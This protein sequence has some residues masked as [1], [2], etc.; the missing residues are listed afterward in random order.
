MD[1]S[2][3]QLTLRE[4]FTHAERLARELIEHL[5]Q[6]FLPKLQTMREL[7]RPVDDLNAEQVPDVTVRNQAKQLL[8]SDEFTQPLLRK[9]D[10]YLQAIDVALHRNA[11]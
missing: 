9:L 7:A 10:D 11:H 6:G 1:P 4:L 5:D 2:L 8:D 3:S